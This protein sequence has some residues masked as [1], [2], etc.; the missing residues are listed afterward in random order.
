MRAGAFRQFE[1]LGDFMK[2]ILGMAAILAAFATPV[3]A[4]D[5]SNTVSGQITGAAGSGGASASSG[6]VGGSAIHGSTV[7]QVTTTG[8]SNGSVLSQTSPSAS[9]VTQYS[10]AGTQSTITSSSSGFAASGGIGGTT[11]GNVNHGF[12]FQGSVT[13]PSSNHY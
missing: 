5:H 8:S 7:T 11:A 4:S 2:R 13:L 10:N 3:F 1:R 6:V 12:A 9:S